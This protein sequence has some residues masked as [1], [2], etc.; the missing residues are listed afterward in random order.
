MKHEIKVLLIEEIEDDQVITSELLKSNRNQKYRV[1]VVRN[2][3]DGL[4]ALLECRHDVCL[5][6]YYLGPHTGLE[7]IRRV[8]APNCRTPMLLLTGDGSRDIDIRASKAG[9]TD[10][11]IKSEI[12]T[13]ILERS[14]R[15]A[16]ERGQIQASRDSAVEAAR[17]KSEF[18]ANMSH[19]IRTP[20]NGIVGM[21]H[22]LLDS[23]LDDEQKELAKTI[24]ACADSLLTIISDILDL[25][26]MEAGKLNFES[27]DFD[28]RY[29]IESAVQ[30]FA[31]E[32][33]AKGIDLAVNV[34]DSVRAS[35]EAMLS[36]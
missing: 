26:K 27:L 16:I 21:T 23:N 14:I 20:M 13:S 12:T 36:D 24:S 31:G 1:E 5:L 33:H 3:E 34:D 22:L 18:L 9:A 29:A 32:A 8:T 7:L 30:Q 10:Y 35:S 6:D 4:A 15:Y 11:L 25:S 17:L 28:P 2:Y 19:E